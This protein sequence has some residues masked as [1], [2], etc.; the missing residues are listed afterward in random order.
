MTLTTLHDFIE[1]QKIQGNTNVVVFQLDQYRRYFSPVA[2]FIL[3]LIGLT[4]SMR[5]VR[6]GMGAQI[7]LGVLLSF[8]YILFSRFSSQFAIG[9]GLNPLLAIWIPNLIFI[10]I[11]FFLYRWAPK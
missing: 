2:T 5:K 7:G 8:S 9:E 3:T 10:V 1:E 4:L 11:A 6:G